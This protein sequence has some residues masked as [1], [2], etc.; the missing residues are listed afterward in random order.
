[1]DEIL[2]MINEVVTPHKS[3]IRHLEAEKEEGKL[4]KAEF[5]AEIRD[6]RGKI[7]GL[8]AIMGVKNN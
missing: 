1:M 5:K 4:E 7:R 6:L 2:T 3:L 8:E